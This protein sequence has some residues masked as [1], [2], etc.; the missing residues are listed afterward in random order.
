[1]KK[2]Q[3][4]IVLGNKVVTGHFR[5]GAWFKNND[6]YEWVEYGPVILEQDNMVIPSKFIDSVGGE[7]LIWGEE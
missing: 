4:T 2:D 1:M 7:L 5:I 3:E 6:T